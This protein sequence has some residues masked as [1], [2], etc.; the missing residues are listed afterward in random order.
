MS[1]AYPL[2]T[3]YYKPEL[4]AAEGDYPQIFILMFLH[5]KNTQ[6]SMAQTLRRKNI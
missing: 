2:P 3:T 4:M 1:K 6:A 5:Q